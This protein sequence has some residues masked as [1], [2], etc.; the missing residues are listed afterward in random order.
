MQKPGMVVL[1]GFVGYIPC[2]LGRLSEGAIYETKHRCGSIKY[3]VRTNPK[4]TNSWKNGR[5]KYSVVKVTRRKTAKN[6]RAKQKLILS[7]DVL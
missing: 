4:Q 2:T 1:V 7:Y 3:F 5:V 6:A